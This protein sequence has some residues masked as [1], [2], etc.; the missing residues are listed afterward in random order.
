M[1]LIL[2]IASYLRRRGPT[3]GAATY[4]VGLV[5]NSRIRAV[6]NYGKT[7][8][9]VSWQVVPAR[10]GSTRAQSDRLATAL[11]RAVGA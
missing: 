10:T 6:P 4:C 8:F 11:E 3:Q 5:G 2:R 7:G 1:P 9:E